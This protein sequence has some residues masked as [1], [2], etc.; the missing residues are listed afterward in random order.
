MLG[1]ATQSH[2]QTGF[3]L[4]SFT[5]ATSN[6]CRDGSNLLAAWNTDDSFPPADVVLQVESQCFPAHRRVLVAHSG[7]FQHVLGTITSTVPNRSLPRSETTVRS[8]DGTQYSSPSATSHVSDLV[9]LSIP[10]QA[11][12]CQAFVILLE[13][14]YTSHLRLDLCNVYEVLLCSRILDIPLATDTCHRFLT[15]IQRHLVPPRRP[16]SSGLAPSAFQDSVTASNVTTHHSF[17]EIPNM[18]VTFASLPLPLPPAPP[19]PGPIFQP[20]SHGTTWMTPRNHN[21]VP[22]V[23]FSPTVVRPIPTNSSQSGFIPLPVRPPTRIVPSISTISYTDTTQFYEKPIC[24]SPAV[25]TSCH[26]QTVNSAP[27]PNDGYDRPLAKATRFSSSVS[28]RPSTPSS[29]MTTFTATETSSRDAS[30]RPPNLRSN[31]PSLEP[32]SLAWQRS[33]NLQELNQTAGS[34]GR[35]ISCGESTKSAEHHRHPSRRPTP[36]T[37]KIAVDVACCDGPVKFQR[38]LNENCSLVITMTENETRHLGRRR[39]RSPDRHSRRRH[40]RRRCHRRRIRRHPPTLEIKSVS[41]R[42]TQTT[43]TDSSSRLSGDNSWDDTWEDESNNDGDNNG[44]VEAYQCFYCRQTFK[45]QCCYVKHKWRHLNPMMPDD[46]ANSGATTTTIE[47]SKEVGSVEV[48]PNGEFQSSNTSNT[49]EPPKALEINVPFYPCKLC[50]CKFPSY[51]FVHKHKRNC[52]QSASEEGGH[53]SSI[54]SSD[55]E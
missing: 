10:L 19:R 11:A 36:R 53:D 52:H 22:V 16:P 44:E 9:F 49:S 41:R 17:G 35:D 4:P 20:F 47:Q 31:S 34:E 27:V 30:S 28:T 40:R 8:S 21:T 33:R 2:S 54:T 5:T 24:E 3:V 26:E 29:S 13:S 12:L 42:Q 23:S 43:D 45:S 7:Y 14:M 50:G 1:I 48:S 37:A 55:P 51:Y 32:E 25:H 46:V 18:A 38:V 15:C 6:I 39:A